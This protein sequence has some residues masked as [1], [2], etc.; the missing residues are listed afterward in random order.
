M[1]KRK[2][3][4]P[5]RIELSQDDLALVKDAAKWLGVTPAEFIIQAAE[6]RARD[7]LQR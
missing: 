3:G 4:T 5:I 2:R 7:L 1:A 6:D